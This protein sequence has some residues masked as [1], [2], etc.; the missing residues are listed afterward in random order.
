MP[1]GSLGQ[2]DPLHGEAWAEWETW[3]KKVGPVW[4]YPMLA[5]QNTLALRVSEA[6][7]LRGLDFKDLWPVSTC[8]P[9]S[10]MMS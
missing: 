5:I 8:L 1:K 2:S 7:Q 6:I 3:C 9:S 4:L 10:T